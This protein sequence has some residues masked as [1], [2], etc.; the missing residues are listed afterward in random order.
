MKSLQKLKWI[1]VLFLALLTSQACD[2]DDF[3]DQFISETTDN[4]DVTN[5]DTDN[6]D[7]TGDDTDSSVDNTNTDDNS[8]E[9]GEEGDITLYNIDGNNLVKVKDFTVTGSALELQN[10]TAKHQEV[11]NLV[12]KI[13]PANYL[14][15]LSDFMIFSGESSGTAGYVFNTASD[16]SRWRM[17]IAIDFAYQGGFNADGE[18]AYTIIHEFGHIL[19]LDNLQVDSSIS[20]SNC[21]NFF[22]GEG[23][24]KTDSY[25][26]KLHKNYWMDIWGEFQTAQDSESAMQSFYD[27]HSSRFVTDY[28]STNPGEDIAEVF[29]TFVTR[30]G[31]AN[32]S[33]IAEKKIQ[34]MYDHSQLVELRNFIRGNMSSAKGR[35]Y[36]PIAGSWKKAKTIGNPKK[37]CTHRTR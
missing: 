19:T 18:L 31:G 36:L 11:W 4:T 3:V 13:I 29:A 8:N 37:G 14:A 1:L 16:L 21:Q 17:G 6:S 26:N 30:N 2:K 22:T 27:K 25:I 20:E 23:C 15:K 12:K 24:A 7:T 34:L 33:N 10:D 5:D 32:G 35:S 28:A 9:T